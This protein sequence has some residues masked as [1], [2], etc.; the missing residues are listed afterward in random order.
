MASFDEAIKIVIGDGGPGSIE[1]GYTNNPNDSG[2]ETKY[3]IS[4]KWHPT[5]DIKNLTLDQA[6]AIY[7]QEKKWDKR[8]DSIESQKVANK[9]FDMVV[10]MDHNA[11]V[12]L[13]RALVACGMRVTVDGI[14]GDETL[15]AI[16][17]TDEVELLEAIRHNQSL[18]YVDCVIHNPNNLTFLKGWIN[19][20]YLT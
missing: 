8:F 19:R 12:I 10:N 5:V 11:I 3:G 15:H 16:Y 1:G 20:T 2:G 9:I 17:Q 13:Q 7:I 4:K 6:K 14:F 18:Y